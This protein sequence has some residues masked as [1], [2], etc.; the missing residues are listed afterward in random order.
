MSLLNV[1]GIRCR[2]GH[3]WVLDGLDFSVNEGEIFA[4]LGPNGAGKSTAFRII[5]GLQRK[6]LGEI[7]FLQKPLHGPLWKR[8][9]LGIGYLPQQS[10]GL[11]KLSVAE[12]I[13]IPL[14]VGG[15]KDPIALL[16]MVGL[17]KH[18]D[19]RAESLSG[20]ERRRMELARCLALKPQ[21]MILDEPFAGLDP[22]A[23]EHLTIV[24]CSV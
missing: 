12:N 10:V 21:L 14:R 4:L 5:A 11:W 19:Q 13:S 24:T 20:G 2:L 16:K 8:A 3:R 18:A 6:F 1:S 17:E 9:Q 22:L 23:V 15:G 7:T